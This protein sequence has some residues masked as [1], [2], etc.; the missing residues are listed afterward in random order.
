MYKS[1]RRVFINVSDTFTKTQLLFPKLKGIKALILRRTGLY[2][3]NHGMYK[4]FFVVVVVVVVVVFFVFFCFFLFFFGGGGYFRRIQVMNKSEATPPGATQ[5]Q[6]GQPRTYLMRNIGEFILKQYNEAVPIS[7][8]LLSGFLPTRGHMVAQK[9][10]RL[11]QLHKLEQLVSEPQLFAR[12][13]TADDNSRL[14]VIREIA[15]SGV[16]RACPAQT[17]PVT[18]RVWV[19]VC[20]DRL[21]AGSWRPTNNT[22]LSEQVER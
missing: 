2:F 20:R 12:F 8:G 3:I 4:L 9:F 6:L 21:F 11:K 18:A 22:R 16:E 14:R 7:C 17:P 1:I 15:V 13:T 5:P 10:H 19:W